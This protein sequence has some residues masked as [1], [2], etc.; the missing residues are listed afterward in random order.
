MVVEPEY[1]P[2]AV[3]LTVNRTRVADA[4]QEN[5]IVPDPVPPVVIVPRSTGTPEATLTVPDPPRTVMPVIAAMVALPAAP[6]PEFSRV[7]G[8]LRV[9][10]AEPSVRTPTEAVRAGCR[11]AKLAVTAESELSVRVC[12][13]AAPVSAPLKLV[14]T[15]PG[16]AVAATFTLL[17]AA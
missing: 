16:L 3:K 17:P 12:G 2:S 7:K 11:G 4:G 13:F 9:P 1:P 15:Y 5:T 6:N 10:A 8:T 14:N